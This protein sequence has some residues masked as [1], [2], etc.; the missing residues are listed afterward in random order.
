MVE[1]HKWDSRT[2]V[3]AFRL[4]IG[5]GRS[6]HPLRDDNAVES[7]FGIETASELLPAMKLMLDEYYS[8]DAKFSAGNLTEMGQIATSEF[9]AKHPETTD[10]IL[11][12]LEWCY[13]F[14]FK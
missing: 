4:W 7:R 12:A 11:E 1:I 5:W 6:N 10:E 9:R 14:D 3:E 8:S 13:T 2:V